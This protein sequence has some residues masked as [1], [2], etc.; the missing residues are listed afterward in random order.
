MPVTTPSFVIKQNT[1]EA[2]KLEQRIHEQLQEIWQ[3][4]A[5]ATVAKY[6]TTMLAKG[7]DRKKIHK[8][9]KAILQETV[10]VQLL[11]WLYRHIRTHGNEYQ[12]KEAP[13]STKSTPKVA[14]GLAKAHEQKELP[15]ELPKEQ[16]P[17]AAPPRAPKQVAEPAS[18]AQ[19]RRPVTE[20]LGPKANQPAAQQQQ[21]QQQGAKQRQQQGRD[22][23]VQQDDERELDG[24][25]GRG[26]AKQQQVSEPG[27]RERETDAAARRGS[28][29]DRE[30]AGGRGRRAGG[31]EGREAGTPSP[32]GRRDRSRSR[33][34][35]RQNR[36][37]R[38]DRSPRRAL[39]RR[40]FGGGTNLL[41]N[42]LADVISQKLSSKLGREIA[43]QL[44]DTGAAR[45]GSGDIGGDEEAA[46]P[47]VIE[48]LGGKPQD[49]GR[50]RGHEGD[51]QA[52]EPVIGSPPK[53]QRGPLG[54]KAGPKSVVVGHTSD[55]QK[56]AGAAGGAG[57]SGRDADG[58]SGD[59]SKAEGGAAD[60]AAGA[61][62]AS[63]LEAV[64][65]QLAEMTK[66]LQSVAGQAAPVAAEPP[67]ERPVERPAAA[68][69]PAGRPQAGR[70]AAPAGQAP[71]VPAPLR[72]RL[73]PAPGA[74]PTGGGDA[75]MAA[76][77][78]SM[79]MHGDVVI[80]GG[81]S[82]PTRAPAADM[83]QQRLASAQ[84][85][86]EMRSVIVE[87]I[88]FGA[89]EAAVG[90]YFGQAGPVKRVMFLPAAFP[91]PAPRTAVVEMADETGVTNAAL[92]DG[93]PFLGMPIRVTL[94]AALL[95]GEL[96]MLANAGPMGQLGPMGG[97]VHPGASQQ[98]AFGGVRPPAQQMHGR[99][100]PHPGGRGAGPGGAPFGQGQGM[101]G[102]AGAMRQQMQGPGG[103]AAAMA[104][105][106]MAGTGPRPQGPGQFG[107]M[108][109]SSKLTWVRPTGTGGAPGGPAA[110]AGGARPAQAAAP[111]PAAATGR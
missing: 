98:G 13:A 82:S 3:P 107:G 97:M 29:R 75:A 95:L 88:V 50:K 9:L 93:S 39:A 53:A 59:R 31:A 92:L 4:D 66:M 72:G 27:R 15:K 108:Q 83:A 99:Q 47:S 85:E 60:G 1:P 32:S 69:P 80:E 103:V 67:A 81:S 19:E 35:D 57:P 43:K 96:D 44:Q 62:A 74:A 87:N 7:H 17:A 2:E 40:A 102:M 12:S 63:E 6:L 89:T 77:A 24:R 52:D 94:K 79:R 51:G 41:G 54:Q 11:E 110:V 100:Q 78:S 5:D 33:S 91:G 109:R 30:A 8:A 84:F 86:A 46:R 28:D 49:A 38:R 104:G 76:M 71:A 22:D 26:R 14:A 16:L 70:L 101:P 18:A 10:T 36:S 42:A 48:R 45:T 64:K 55:A 106:G 111:A 68:V 37:P 90:M 25:A 56:P 23:S 73:G 58:A 105:R 61:A 21:P 20:R 65:K 34:G